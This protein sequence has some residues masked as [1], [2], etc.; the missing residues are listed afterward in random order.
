LKLGT[1]KH[2]VKFQKW[3]QVQKRNKKTFAELEKWLSNSK[4]E[5]KKVSAYLLECKMVVKS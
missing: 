3:Q 2:K 5:I 1:K 4:K